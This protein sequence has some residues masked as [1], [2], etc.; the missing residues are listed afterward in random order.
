MDLMPGAVITPLGEVV[1]HGFGIGIILGEIPPRATGAE[2]VENSVDDV[3]QVDG[4]RTTTRF[5][6]R[7]ETFEQGPLVVIEVAEISLSHG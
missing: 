6:V 4:A 5:G 7:Q 3:S 2:D 1:V